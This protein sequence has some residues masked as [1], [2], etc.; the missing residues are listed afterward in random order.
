MADDHM[1]PLILRKVDKRGIPTISLILL[2]IFTVLCCNFDFTTLVM[3]AT[4]IQLY[5]YLFLIATLYKLRKMYPIE[6]RKQMGLTV[7]PGGR[8]IISLLSL[9][10][11]LYTSILYKTAFI[12]IKCL[13]NYAKLESLTS[14]KSHAYEAESV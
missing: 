3:A 14:L 11:L 9:S 13:V 12:L 6:A 8:L 1:F 5:L 7:M 2:G 4:P 10:C